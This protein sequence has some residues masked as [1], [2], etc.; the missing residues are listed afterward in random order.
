ML[1]TLKMRVE[2]IENFN[3]LNKNLKNEKDPG[4]TGVSGDTQDETTLL[5]EVK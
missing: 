5:R 2:F 1:L 4:E 3:L